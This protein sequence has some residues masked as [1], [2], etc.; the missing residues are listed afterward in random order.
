MATLEWKKLLKYGDAFPFVPIRGYLRNLQGVAN[1]LRKLKRWEEAYKIY[2]Q[3][4]KYIGQKF[5]E[6]IERYSTYT[7]YVV[8]LFFFFLQTCLRV[9]VLE[10]TFQKSC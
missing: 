9:V 8:K 1:C 2:M 10:Q 7:K 3:L 5:D 6:K 4:D